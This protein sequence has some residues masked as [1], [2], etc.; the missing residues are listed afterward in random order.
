[1]KQSLERTPHRRPAAFHCLSTCLPLLSFTL[2]L[3]LPGC[4][5]NPYPAAQERQSIIYTA[6]IDD[7]KRL[8]PSVS[9]LV[10]EGQILSL[11]YNSYFQYH[12]LKQKRLTLELALGAE[13]PTRKPA[14]AWV[15]KDGKK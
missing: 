9:Y 11:I 13:M 14:P 7:P 10:T 5:N 2:L 12:Y 8:D 1:M 4:G 3:A 15:M 6:L